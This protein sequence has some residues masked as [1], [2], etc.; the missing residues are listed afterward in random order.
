MADQDAD[1]PQPPPT[2][3]CQMCKRNVPAAQTVL[4]SGRLLCFGCAG[5]WF[6][7]EEQ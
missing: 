5:A 3:V 2:V 1:E 6:D 4:F 7:D